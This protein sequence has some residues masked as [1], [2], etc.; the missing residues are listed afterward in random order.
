MAY[1]SWCVR[2]EEVRGN[3]EKILSFFLAVIMVAQ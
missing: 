1:V 2:D 3:N